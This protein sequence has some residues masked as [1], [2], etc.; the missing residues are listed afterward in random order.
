[1]EYSNI[2]INKKDVNISINKK[3]VS[4]FYCTV[5]NFVI[6]GKSSNRNS[7]NVF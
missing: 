3:D 2:S 6:S 5:T 4:T 7:K 1:M